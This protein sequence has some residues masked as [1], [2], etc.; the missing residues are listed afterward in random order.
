MKADR[1]AIG[2]LGANANCEFSE[3][4]TPE[5]RALARALEACTV[6]PMPKGAVMVIHLRAQAEA[7]ARRRAWRTVWAMAAA[8][9]LLL[10]A[11]AVYRH[12]S[13]GSAVLVAEAEPAAE[14]AGDADDA[15]ADAYAQEEADW[16]SP[17]DDEFEALETTLLAFE[18]MDFATE[19]SAFPSL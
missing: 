3:S 12:G 15:E 16:L 18:S 4:A 14:T 11:W 19:G 13:S 9:A 6:P 2:K 7:A 17:Y 10:G 1:N 5:E 8:L